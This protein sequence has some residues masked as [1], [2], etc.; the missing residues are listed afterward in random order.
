MQTRVSIQFR[1]EDSQS[2]EL[3]LRV[4]ESYMLYSQLELNEREGLG[5][6]R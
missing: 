2:F 4:S 5:R 1:S 6:V 3:V